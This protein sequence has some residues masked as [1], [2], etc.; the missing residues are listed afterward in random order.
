MI[1]QY[2]VE[3]LLREYTHRD[4]AKVG[5]VGGTLTVREL[6]E[7]LG[8]ALKADIGRLV[9]HHGSGPDDQMSAEHEQAIK[10]ANIVLERP[11]GDPDDDLAVLSRQ[12]LRATER[13]ATHEEALLNERA[14]EDCRRIYEMSCA[15]A[16]AS[17]IAPQPGDGMLVRRVR[18]LLWLYHQA[19]AKAAYDDLVAALREDMGDLGNNEDADSA[20]A[21]GEHASGAVGAQRRVA[22]PSS[23]EEPK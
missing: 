18:A 21:T 14:R 12:F 16:D 11:S 2:R 10:L 17:K 19:D 7:L 23:P 9:P 4:D 13:A 6:R 1:D 5:R 8:I 15:W 22:T 3:E 20:Q